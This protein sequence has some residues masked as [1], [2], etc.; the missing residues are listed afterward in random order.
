MKRRLWISGVLALLLS[1]CGSSV[2]VGDNGVDNLASTRVKASSQELLSSAVMGVFQ[3]EGFAVLSRTSQSI[4]FTKQGG[5]SA[6]VMWKTL[7]NSNPVMIRPTVSWRPSGAGEYWLGCQVEVAQ[8]STV[9]GETVRQPMMVGK[10]AY[11]DLLR[12]V[13]RRVER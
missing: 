2:G 6:D 13:K 1:A 5:R 4:T 9:F 3:G 11:N 8:E 12:Q 7:G 10:S